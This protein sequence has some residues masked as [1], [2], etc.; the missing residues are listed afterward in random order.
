[1]NSETRRLRAGAP[2]RIERAWR[3]AREPGAGLWMGSA[4]C[5]AVALAMIGLA[6]GGIYAALRLTA[7]WSLL[8]FWPAYA[9]GAMTTL[10]GS[11]FHILAR[12]GREFGLAY[13]AAQ[14]VHFGLVACLVADSG[15]PLM[16]AI[17]PFFAVGVVWTYLLALS[18]V[19]PLSGLFAPQRW[20]ILRAVGLEY[21]ALLFFADLVINPIETHGKL[22]LEYLPFSSLIIIGP[23]LRVAAAMRGLAHRP[24]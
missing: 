17:M 20:R 8:L 2:W 14:L 7:R 22:P 15:K 19:Q 1:M 12:H 11:R 16:Q 21:L 9:G 18:S 23:L 4:F 24:N 3:V 10:F 6:T 5:I 13:A